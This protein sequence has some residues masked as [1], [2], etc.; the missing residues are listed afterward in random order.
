[1]EEVEKRRQRSELFLQMAKNLERGSKIADTLGNTQ[2]YISLELKR[3]GIYSRNKVIQLLDTRTNEEIALEGN[4]DVEAVARV[5]REIE[6]DRAIKEKIK[7]DCQENQKETREEIQKQKAEKD[8]LLLSM[9]RNI[10]NVMDMSIRL[11]YTTD[12]IYITLN[13]AGIYT[14]RKV[15]HLLD[16]KTDEEIASEGNVDVKAVARVRRER[17]EER[18]RPSQCS[19]RQKKLIE[20]A[21]N[22]DEI[23]DIMHQ[24]GYSSITYIQNQLKLAGIYSKAQVI[25]LLDK[26]TDKEIALEGK[27]DVEAVARVRQEV[28]KKEQ[29]ISKNGNEVQFKIDMLKLRGQIQSLKE[30]SKAANMVMDY[31]IQKM[32]DNYGSLLTQEHYALFAYGYVKVREYM[33]AIE[34]GEEYLDLETSSLSALQKRINEILGREKEKS[35]GKTV[36]NPAKPHDAHEE[37]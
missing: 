4:V 37:R 7:K 18:R 9:A 35:N 22:L 27:V 20:M 30:V 12:Y 10:E 23:H 17:E 26:K 5:R 6:N 16:E 19:T 25:E 3:A 14:R 33:K 29:Q 15:I 1:M 32:L 28:K 34:I 13:H 11:G 2:S 31:N 36:D 8:K 21:K 24:L